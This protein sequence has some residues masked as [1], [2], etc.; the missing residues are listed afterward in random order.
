[1]NRCCSC[2]VT[3]YLS[4]YLSI[5]LLC[6]QATRHN[7]HRRVFLRSDPYKK[8]SSYC[9]WF[10]SS[11]DDDPAGPG[12]VLF[13]HWREAPLDQ[14]FSRRERTTNNVYR[15]IHTHTHTYVRL[16]GR[17][18]IKVR[19]VPNSLQVNNYIWPAARGDT[20]RPYI[21]RGSQLFLVLQTNS[22]NVCPMQYVYRF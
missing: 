4:I 13:S 5:Y 12:R 19:P 8:R 7:N 10:S 6:V 1:M 14:L 17:D 18:R 3:I 20:T 15:Y 11:I 16:Q 22:I 2:L 21:C 9:S